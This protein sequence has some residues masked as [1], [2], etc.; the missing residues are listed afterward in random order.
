[1]IFQRRNAGNPLAS[2]AQRSARPAPCVT[3]LL[4]SGPIKDPE[5]L[6]RVCV[7]WF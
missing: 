2:G 5:A 3:G 7:T 4:H 6:S 1:M